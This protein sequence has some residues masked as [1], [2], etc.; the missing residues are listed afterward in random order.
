MDSTHQIQ[1]HEQ[2]SET[3]GTKRKSSS[4]TK[5][6][7]DKSK[8]SSQHSSPSGTKSSSSSAVDLT[9]G[10]EDEIY[11][12]YKKMG[13]DDLKDC[14][15]WNRQLL[16]GSKQDLVKRCVDG[17]KVSNCENVIYYEDLTFTF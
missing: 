7:S 6:P 14:L 9:T 12:I 11:M 1:I 17:Q 15:R 5:V 4:E 2:L 10:D 13:I 3:A 16:K 8:K